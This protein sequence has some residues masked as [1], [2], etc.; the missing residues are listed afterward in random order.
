MRFAASFY[1]S[2]TLTADSDGGEIPLVLSTPGT[3]QKYYVLPESLCYKLPAHIDLQAGVLVEPLAV[4]VHAVRLAQI[5]PQTKSV[6]ITGAGT[7]GLVMA[8]V[9]C[10]YGAGKLVLVDIDDKKLKFAKQWL[11]SPKGAA[12]KAGVAVFTINSASKA[13]TSNSNSSSSATNDLV[14]RINEGFGLGDGAHVALEASGSPAAIKLCIATLRTDG[15]MVQTG[16]SKNPNM[17]AFPI[18]DL[19]EKEIHVHGAFR[20][21]QGDFET[22]RDLLGRGVVGDVSGL[23]SKVWG[24]EE[25]EMAWKATRDGDGNGVKNLI[26]CPG[27]NV[28]VSTT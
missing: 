13:V 3:L 4:A 26:R 9:S 8:A 15:H 6:L 14:R 24:F 23:I 1:E 22:A 28:D 11:T 20:Y 27:I 21:K 18:C 16:L 2:D 7:I 10:A 17:D 12:A 25:Y 5:N 19:S